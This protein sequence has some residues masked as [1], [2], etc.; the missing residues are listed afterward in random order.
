MKT[1]LLSLL[2]SAAVF[3]LSSCS[4]SNPTGPSGSEQMLPLKLG[5]NW[6]MQY[7]FYDTTGAVAGTFNDTVTVAKD[8]VASN[9]T[10]YDVSSHVINGYFADESD[11]LWI[12]SSSGQFLAFKSPAN[13]GDTWSFQTDASTS[14]QVTLE[15]NGTS[16]TVPK[17]TYTCHDYKVAVNSGGGFEFYMCPGVGIVALDIYS[18]TESGRSYKYAYGQLLSFTLK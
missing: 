1:I 3:S 7:T 14:Y 13:V 11:G 8:T 9:I 10:W 16:V 2:L 17:G 15:S 4:K 6:V 12:L 5:D 18:V